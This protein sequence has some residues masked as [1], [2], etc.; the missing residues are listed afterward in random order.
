MK[1]VSGVCRDFIS[2]FCFCENAAGPA[3]NL[4]AASAVRTNP[5]TSEYEPSSQVLRLPAFSTAAAH[6]TDSFPSSSR[7]VSISSRAVI[8]TTRVLLTRNP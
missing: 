3:E 5:R 4:T 8:G 7:S 1:S 6:F 2:A